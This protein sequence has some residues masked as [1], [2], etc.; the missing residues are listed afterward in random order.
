MALPLPIGNYLLRLVSASCRRIVNCF[1]LKAPPDSPYGQPTTI[2]RAPGIRAFVDTAEESGVRGFLPLHETL[3]AVA[4]DKLYTINEAGTVTAL[5]GD[6]IT[7]SGRVRMAVNS[8]GQIVIGCSDNLVYSSDG[9]TVAQITDTTVTDGNG[10]ADPSFVDGYIVLRKPGTAQ[11]INTGINDL[12]FSALDVYTAEGSP[13]NLVGLMVNNRELILPGE[14]STE[15]AYNAD[16]AEGSPFSRSPSGFHEI[17]C[18][19]GDSLA[20]Q[21]NTVLMLANDKTFRRLSQSWQQVSHDGID[22][23]VAAMTLVSDCYSL[24]WRQEGHHFVAW[25]FPN[26][27]RTLVLDL[28]TGE[29]HERESRID[30]VSLGRWRVQC[31]AQIWGKQI[32]GDSESGKIGILDPDTHEE[33]G[34][35]QACSVTFQ[36]IYNAGREVTLKRFELGI[37]SGQGTVT[38]QGANPL[39]TLFISRDG[40]NNF[41]AK[42]MRE[43][44]KIGEYRRRVQWNALGASTRF[45]PRIEF[46]DPIPM[47]I[48]DAQ[49]DT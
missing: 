9:A 18:A 13:D 42:P 12:T 47:M 48:L 8:N 49:V 31:I 36:P 41:T 37:S 17:G 44:G 32:V 23:I 15:L 20:S 16:N 35:P 46:S 11:I 39:A 5:T 22:Q 26:A 1:A 33:W 43:L 2:Y 45:V 28:N 25:T 7:G 34:E 10:A 3:Y 24:T 21:D 38:G 27:S 40:G 30:T 6:S 14:D 19:A 4:G 29:W